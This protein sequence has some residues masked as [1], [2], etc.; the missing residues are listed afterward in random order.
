MNV[1]RKKRRQELAIQYKEI[2]KQTNFEGSIRKTLKTLKAGIYVGSPFVIFVFDE[3]GRI[4]IQINF[5]RFGPNAKIFLDPV[6]YHELMDL[7]IE[8]EVSIKPLPFFDQWVE[9]E[10]F[11]T[12]INH[13][14]GL[15][16]A[17]V[18]KLPGT[19]NIKTFNV[20]SEENNIIS[21]VRYACT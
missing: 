5:N 9:K 1:H 15:K 21:L 17:D 3:N 6:W 4:L 11:G 7:A 16:N 8:S 10:S 12:M 13:L 18:F 14:V 2:V 19:K 20:E